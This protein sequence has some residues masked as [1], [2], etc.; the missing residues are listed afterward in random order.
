MNKERDKILKEYQK[1]LDSYKFND[2]PTMVPKMWLTNE[3][4]ESLGYSQEINY[5]NAISKIEWN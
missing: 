3:E 4:A 2:Y 5:D 1:A